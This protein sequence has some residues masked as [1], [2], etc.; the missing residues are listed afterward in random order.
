MLEESLPVLEAI[1]RMPRRQILKKLAHRDLWDL[2]GGHHAMSARSQLDTLQAVGMGFGNYS[3][4][5]RA[6][7]GESLHKQAAYRRP[8]TPKVKPGESWTAGLAAMFGNAPGALVAPPTAIAQA[9]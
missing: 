9:P 5:V 8:E 2:V 4:E 6:S 7:I 3:P 1:L